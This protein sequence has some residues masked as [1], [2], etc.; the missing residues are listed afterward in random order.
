MLDGPKKNP[1]SRKLLL[2]AYNASIY[3]ASGL[4]IR[5]SFSGRASSCS[6]FAEF[7]Q[8]LE[9]KG[10]RCLAARSGLQRMA[11]SAAM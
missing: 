10:R 8:E 1:W 4:L 6:T 3:V 7:R 2:D 9:A 11:L 5:P